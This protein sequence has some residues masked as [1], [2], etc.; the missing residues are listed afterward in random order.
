MAAT[1]AFFV[2]IQDLAG[3]APDRVVSGGHTPYFHAI[4]EV[5]GK[6]VVHERRTGLANPLE[7]DHRGIKHR[8]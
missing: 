4:A 1:K 2:H 6:K 5:L 7:Q 8:Y 3:Q